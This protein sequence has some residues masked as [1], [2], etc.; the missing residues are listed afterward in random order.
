MDFDISLTFIWVDIAIGRFKYSR[1]SVAI[2]EVGFENILRNIQ[3]EG[4]EV[5]FF[6]CKTI[7]TWEEALPFGTP[8]PVLRDFKNTLSQSKCIFI[9]P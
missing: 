9:L 2:F 1:N 4:R 8:L 7:N 3:A 6:K 5:C